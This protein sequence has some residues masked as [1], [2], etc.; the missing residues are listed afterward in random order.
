MT[1]PTPG[2]PK[3][4]TRTALIIGI[5]VSVVLLIGVGVVALVLGLS[6]GS[7][8]KDGKKDDTTTSSQTPEDA[9]RAFVEA[10]NDGDCEILVLHP[11]ADVDSVEDCE[12][13]L[14]DARDDAEDVG[15]D[16]DSFA[17]EID[18]LE[19]TS[20]SDSE[21]SIALEVT[22]SY[23]LDGDAET[24]ETTFEYELEKDGGT[25]I[26]VDVETDKIEVPDSAPSDDEN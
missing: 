2:Q 17:L 10:T 25:W 5:A 24:Y 20:E 13:K 6:G 18:D 16:F 23:E 11:V 9:M 12:S 15:Y 26:V 4:T 22:Q 14:D 21:A 3:D 7:D 19:V 8:E 1:H